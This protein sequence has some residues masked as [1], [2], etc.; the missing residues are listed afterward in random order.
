[1]YSRFLVYF[2]SSVLLFFF[3]NDSKAQS[4]GGVSN[5]LSLWLKANTTQP[6][7]I[8]YNAGGQVSNWK[9]ETGTYNVTQPNAANQPVFG[10]VT[11]NI[12]DFNFNPFIQFNRLNAT[13]LLNA[14]VTPDLLGT[15]GTVLVA[16]NK[17]DATGQGSVLTYRS[18]VNYRFQIKPVFR[19][20]NGANNI[21]YK[22]E[23][24]VASNPNLTG[25]VY[26]Y[27]ENDAF[28]LNMSGTGLN[29]RTR[30]NATDCGAPTGN[31]GIYFPSVAV[32][33]SLGSNGGTVEYVGHALAEV[34]M[35]DR[36]LTAA[37]AN[38]VESYLAIKYGI[39]FDEIPTSPVRTN[40]VSS[41]GVV[42]WDKTINNGYNSNIFGIG[43][44][45][46]SGLLQKQ[47]HSVNNNA[48][49]SLYNGNTAGQFPVMN[50]S[51]NTTFTSD[52]SYLVL[53][54]NQSS[55]LLDIC[56]HSGRITRMARTWKAQKTGVI[57]TVTIAF[58]KDSLPACV[59]T[60]FIS[61]N[62]LFPGGSTRV[63]RLSSQGNFKYAAV[64]V[65]NNEYIS[66]GS[67]SIQIPII[68]T[69]RT[70]SGNNLLL[71][72]P[73]PQPCVNYRW[74]GSATSTTP[75][76]IND[77]LIPGAFSGDT[78][79]YIQME[80]PGSC[81]SLDRATAV[82]ISSIVTSPLFITDTICPGTG[83]TIQ[84]LNPNASFSYNWYAV[85]NGGTALTTGPSYA[86]PDI[87]AATTY[88]LQAD[89]S[90]CSSVRVPVTVEI[91][92]TPGLPA[93][94][95]PVFVCP[96]STATLQVQN[97]GS[98]ISYTWYD[99]PSRTANALATGPTYT[100]PA[101]TTDTVFYVVAT[102]SYGCRDLPAS[103]SVNVYP[104][105]APPV[106]ISPVSICPNTTA[107]LQVQNPV[108]GVTYTWYSSSS[109]GSALGTGDV[110]TTG[111]LN[112]PTS[113]YV[114]VTSA[115]GCN[116]ATRSPVVI[117]VFTPPAAPVITGDLNIC[118]NQPANLAVSNPQNG[119]TYSWYV[120][121]SSTPVATGTT[122]TT[123]TVTGPISVSVTATDA[124][125]CAGTAGTATV[126]IWTT[127]ASPVVVVIDSTAYSLTFSWN[128]VPGASG[129]IVSTDGINYSP[130]SSGN[131]GTT[132]VV[133]G[134]DFDQ[135]VTLYVIALNAIDCRN[136]LPDSATGKTLPE[137]TDVYVPTAFTPNGDGL[138]DMLH[139]LGNTIQS[140]EFSVYNR[141]GQ[142]IFESTNQRNG[143]NGR[144]RNKLQ[145]TGTYVYYVRA[146]MLD[147]TVKIK[148]G[149]V[150]LLR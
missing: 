130:P 123:D 51:N 23:L 66:F 133:T 93:T 87:S 108:A 45:D 116:S 67:D 44:D 92:P 73:Q 9:S 128:A 71:T 13:S 27:A 118:A 132:H 42:I 138:N 145:A 72:I 113:F 22:F 25:T 136:S 64:S 6:G 55:T 98:G 149:T 61:D 141:Y 80:G 4:P 101:V 39:T 34:I 84:V 107:T 24:V 121:N 38:R 2:F 140:L 54:D 31:T 77:T 144:F 16:T 1:M 99:S 110:F 48:P 70:C 32:G 21:G 127:L 5:N 148:K 102:N 94:N 103:V 106:V 124:N 83:A 10:R 36:T 37:E 33:L 46:A 143:W 58:H 79:Y 105:P 115:N 26:N 114:E 18:G 100:T 111:T 52:N 20:Q 82:V 85:P 75:I 90:R 41:G 78:T 40:Y 74:Y 137:I 62:P 11:S 56:I 47:S 142:K 81:L 86:T 76:T 131:Q 59:S 122:Y 150:L 69:L 117:N 19:A 49:L 88:Y 30:R 147:S 89:S 95:S 65:N 139:V 28:I 17:Y 112:A 96:N 129:Y 7:N 135:T 146:V 109:G 8:I 50:D 68:D 14:A 63:T 134:L 53:G 57:D 119:V 12:A 104:I 91:H 97:P 35:Y 60:V 43:R 3:L 125:G 126:Q 15:S 29:S 120:S